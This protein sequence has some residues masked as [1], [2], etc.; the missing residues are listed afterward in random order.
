MKSAK[1][2]LWNSVV[3]C[4]T[5]FKSCVA[6]FATSVFLCGLFFFGTTTADNRMI[7]GGRKNHAEIL[8]NE[9]NRRTLGMVETN[10]ILWESGLCTTAMST[11]T[12]PKFSLAYLPRPGVDSR[13]KFLGTYNHLF[14]Y[15]NDFNTVNDN[16]VDLVFYSLFSKFVEKNSNNNNSTCNFNP[17]KQE[18]IALTRGNKTF[19]YKTKESERVQ[20]RVKPQFACRLW[21]TAPRNQ[22]THPLDHRT[23]FFCP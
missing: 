15:R 11:Y 6:A 20:W 9:L 1:T 2:N 14:W 21:V 23:F 22:S 17:A 3:V 19:P 16:D 18:R 13:R 5:F 4:S 7:F 8:R 12:P 10:H